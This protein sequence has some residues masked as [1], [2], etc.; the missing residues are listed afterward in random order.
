MDN[1]QYYSRHSNIV[2][3]V[4]EGFQLMIPENEIYKTQVKRNKQKREFYPH[5]IYGTTVNVAKLFW[6][7]I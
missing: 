3:N 4:K 7:V 6:P 2:K 1:Y 5:Y